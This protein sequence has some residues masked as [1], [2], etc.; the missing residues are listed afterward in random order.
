MLQ[1]K[2]QYQEIGRHLRVA[3]DTVRPLPGG[4]APAAPAQHC[5]DLRRRRTIIR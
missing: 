1:G 5:R 4:D 3:Q 2:K